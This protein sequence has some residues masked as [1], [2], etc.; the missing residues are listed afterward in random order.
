MKKSLLIILVLL[1]SHF[2]FAQEQEEEEQKKGFQKE[3]VFVGGNFGL[4]FGNYTLVNVSPQVGY[5]FNNYL[6]AGLGMNF[7]YVSLKEKD[8]YNDPYRKT[9]Q[10]VVGLNVFG[11]VYPIRQFMLQVQPEVNYLFGKEKYYERS[12]Q[13]AQEYNL[14]TEIVPSLLAGGGLVLPSGRGA[15]IISVFYDVLQNESSPYGNK[16]ILNFTFNVGL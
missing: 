10:G 13:P 11:R 14:N 7:Q 3:K 5:R 9:S 16:P 1:N 4:S 6:A 2:L 8:V 12:Y 15:M